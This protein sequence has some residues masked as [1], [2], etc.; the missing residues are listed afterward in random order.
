V[1]VGFGFSASSN[2]NTEQSPSSKSNVSLYYVLCFKHNSFLSSAELD[3]IQLCRWRTY[4]CVCV[5]I[6]NGHGQ[7]SGDRTKKSGEKYSVVW[8]CG[9]WLL[10]RQP[11]DFAICELWLWLWLWL[12]LILSFSDGDEYRNSL[13][14]FFDDDQLLFRLRT[15]S[16][17]FHYSSMPMAYT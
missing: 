7:T 17:S 11:P 2:L 3:Y 10:R 8:L 12:S 1:G 15:W 13:E 5:V 4:V 14:R 16:F 9:L 6:L